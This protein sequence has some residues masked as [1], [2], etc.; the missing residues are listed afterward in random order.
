MTEATIGDIKQS[1]DKDIIKPLKDQSLTL[2]QRLAQFDPD[3]HG[4]EVMISEQLFG[5]SYSNVL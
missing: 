3:R 5:V 1:I 4:G 2:E